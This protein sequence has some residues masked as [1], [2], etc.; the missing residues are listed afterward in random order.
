MACATPDMY[1]ACP[2]H[3]DIRNRL[4]G[5]CLAS[6]TNN[7]LIL[8]P[9]PSELKMNSKWGLS[10]HSLL[11]IFFPASDGK[12]VVSANSLLGNKTFGWKK[13]SLSL[14]STLA[15]EKQKKNLFIIHSPVLVVRADVMSCR[16]EWV[17]IYI[18]SWTNQDVQERI[19]LCFRVILLQKF[20]RCLN[21]K[22]M[23]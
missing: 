3:A 13:I 10:C 22:G 14:F 20:R 9:V 7:I 16:V 8:Q 4:L 19:I 1:V 17:F 21:K 6:R 18:K 11:N 23:E 12:N 2:F 5:V 15:V